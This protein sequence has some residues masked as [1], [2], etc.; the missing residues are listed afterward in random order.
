MSE[1]I[2]ERYKKGVEVI[3]SAGGTPVPVTDNTVAILKYIVEEKHLDFIM[4]FKGKRSQTMEQ[5]KE[6]TGFS[7]EEINEHVRVLA[8]TGLIMNQPSSS[9]LMIFRLMPFVN[10][11]VYEYTFMKK[12]EYNDW[13]KG[14]AKLYKKL[15]EEFKGR[16][17]ANYDAIVKNYLPRMRPI[18]RTVPY[19]ENFESGDNINIVIDKEIE[20]PEEKIISTQK[21][22]EIIQKFDEIAV[23]HCYCRHFRDLVGE[24]CKQTDIRENCFT[25]GKSARYTT[26]QGF[27]RMISKEEAIEILKKSEKDGLV[28]KAYHPNMDFKRDEDSI[29]NCCS[30]CCGQSKNITSNLSSFIAR[31]DHDLCTGCGTCVEKCYSGAK[32]L[33]DEGKAETNEERCIGCGICAAFCPEGAVSLVEKPRIVRLA[34]PRSNYE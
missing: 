20:V 17:L 11:G 6:A 23:G 30:D 22:E 32:E 19:T 21:V 7:E 31:V 18:D 24:S 16:M 34:P 27:A 28:H 12:L 4:A 9:G 8:K 1:A 25:F 26:E 13:E 5:I 2:D 14:L 10:V 15:N 29:C 3:N 33:N